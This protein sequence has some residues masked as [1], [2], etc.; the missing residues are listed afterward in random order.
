[1]L[2][3]HNLSCRVAVVALSAC[4]ALSSCASSKASSD[5]DSDT[6]THSS[7]ASVAAAMTNVPVKQAGATDIKFAAAP[8]KVSA[9]FP[10][11]A[12]AR[13]LSMAVE[14]VKGRMLRGSWQSGASNTAVTSQVIASSD[15]VVGVLLTNT[16]T[17]GGKT[18]TIPATVWYSTAGQQSYS[19]P[20]LVKSSEWGSLVKALQDAGKD[21]SLDPTRIDKALRAQSAP[22][23]EGPALGFDH[24]GNLL[25]SF[26]S[27]A[28]TDSAVTLSVPSDKVGSMLST[29]GTQAQKASTNPSAFTGRSGQAAD[30]EL[31]AK[32]SGDRP[33]T[34]IGPDCRVLHCVAVTYDDGPSAMTPQLLETIKKFKVSI[35][36]FQMGNS[37]QT[38][39]DTA[40]KVAAAGMEIGNHTVSHPNLPVKTPQRITWELERN[41]QIIKGYTGATPLLFRP[42][43]GAHNSTVDQV[44][45]RNGM[46]I[47]QWQ[48]DSEDWKNRNPDTTYT[49]VMTALPYHAPIILEHDIQKASIDA[50]ARIYTDLEAKGKTL[51]SVSELSLNSG[52]YKAGH[53]YCNGTII[54]QDGYDCKG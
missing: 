43:Y 38:F 20:A 2:P 48:I 41:S 6:T 42:P 52:G 22:Y 47:M 10:R 46:S 34:A 14:V 11:F 8:E 33:S 35:T 1:M 53:A 7:A 13:N 25:A 9:T 50:A 19:S 54:A 31:T 3:K 12:Q 4:L 23:G 21:A 28:V 32:R 51:V 26:R 40:R 37:I 49:N 15:A 18:Y 39:P 29:F 16:T 27:G 44:A 24:D 5:G 30:P 17:V 45:Q 36:F